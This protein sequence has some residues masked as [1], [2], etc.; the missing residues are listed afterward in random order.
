MLEVT[1]ILIEETVIFGIIEVQ[2]LA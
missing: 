1:L 2:L